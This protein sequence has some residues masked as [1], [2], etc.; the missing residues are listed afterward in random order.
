MVHGSDATLAGRSYMDVT[1]TV[2]ASY[3]M[4]DDVSLDPLMHP[5]LPLYVHYPLS[6][7]SVKICHLLIFM[8]CFRVMC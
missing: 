1:I 7:L 3:V 2:P 8:I 6:P 4:V 5:M